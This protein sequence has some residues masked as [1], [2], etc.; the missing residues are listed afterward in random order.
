MLG[1]MRRAVFRQHHLLQRAGAGVGLERQ[2]ARHEFPRRDDVADTQ[3]RRDRL[4]E[5]ADVDDAAMLAHGVD[6]RRALVVPD[7]VGVAIVLEDRHAVLCRQPQ[8]LDAATFRH[9][10]SGRILHGRDGVDVLRPDA[11]ALEVGERRGHRIGAHAVAVE[12]HADHVHAHALHAVDRAL[13]GLLLEQHGVAARQQR[14]VDQ[15]ERLQRTRSHQDVVGGAGNARVT[16]ELADQ[17]VAQPPVTLRAVGE[18]VGR[19]RTAFPRHHR[20]GRG[21]QTFER[22]R[23]AVVVAA[24]EIVLGA[25]RSSAQQRAAGP[26]AAAARNRT[27]SCLLPT[28]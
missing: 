11:L 18:P 20:V 2:R 8:Q 10:G 21:D 19:Q 17:E 6:R 14:P 25:A 13:V 26:R 15:V 16:L 7:Q 5:R 28:R 9:D 1:E 3:R 24:G 22:D 4:G 27:M 23:I 12:R